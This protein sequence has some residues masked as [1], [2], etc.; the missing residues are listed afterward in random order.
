MYVADMH[1]DSFLKVNAENGL[2][3]EYNTSKKY[4]FLQ[5]FAAY[6]PFKA[7]GL[8]VRRREAR[9]YLDIYAYE[10][11]RLGLTK[12]EDVRSLYYATDNNVP[13]AMFAIEGGAGLLADSDELFTFYKAGLRVMSFAWDTNELA[14]SA[15]DECD[16]AW[17]KDAPSS[18]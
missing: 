8:D 10:C 1:C 6:T 3:N 9:K 16:E 12:I 4:P 14:T 17:Q 15:Y 18:E 13:S 11:E 2:I 5:F 7:R